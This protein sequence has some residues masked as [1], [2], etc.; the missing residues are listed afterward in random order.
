[1][2][3]MCPVSSLISIQVRRTEKKIH[4]KSGRSSSWDDGVVSVLVYIAG[5]V[6]YYYFMI[7]FLLLSNFQLNWTYVS[8]VR[9]NF[10]VVIVVVV[11]G[12]LIVWCLLFP[13]SFIHL[14]VFSCC[15]CCC[16]RIWFRLVS[17][18]AYFLSFCAVVARMLASLSVNG[19]FAPSSPGFFA[20]NAI[21]TSCSFVVAPVDADVS[22]NGVNLLDDVGVWRK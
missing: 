2:Y 1:M 13:L 17:T 14:F 21:S 18:V 16:P 5:M 12:W 6:V 11:H 22:E 4:I 15:F 20:F 9:I 8:Y 7:G 3:C 10:V 19:F